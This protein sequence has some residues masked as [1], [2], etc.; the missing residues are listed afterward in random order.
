MG[1]KIL[2]RIAIDLFLLT[3]MCVDIDFR[4]FSVYKFERIPL[5]INKSFM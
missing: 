1:E 3:D 4:L 5:S 2:Y